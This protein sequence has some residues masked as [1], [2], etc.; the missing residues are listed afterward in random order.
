MKGEPLL[1]SRQAA[2]T[3][4]N[5]QP[6]LVMGCSVSFWFGPPPPS[7]PRLPGNLSREKPRTALHSRSQTFLDFEILFAR[8]VYGDATIRRGKQLNTAESD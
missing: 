6:P 5:H 7:R 8:L 4:L 1:E 2:P 3:P